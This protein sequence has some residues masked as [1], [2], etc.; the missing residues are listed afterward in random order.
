MIQNENFFT[1]PTASTD[2]PRVPNHP[3]NLRCHNNIG[4]SLRDTI[5]PLASVF[6]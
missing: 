4:L 3:L 1:I 5:R 2:D 6:N